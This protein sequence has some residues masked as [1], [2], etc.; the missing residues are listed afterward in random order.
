LSISLSRFVLNLFYWLVIWDAL[1]CQFKLYSRKPIICLLGIALVISNFDLQLC[2]AGEERMLCFLPLHLLWLD[3]T[4]C[5]PWACMDE[6]HDRLCLPISVA[7]TLFF[8]SESALTLIYA[9][10]ILQ[11]P[12]RACSSSA[13]TPARLMI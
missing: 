9:Q 7:G 5:C 11:Y 10:L 8:L 13:N 3:K 4:G 2:N 1:I 6:Q 12:C